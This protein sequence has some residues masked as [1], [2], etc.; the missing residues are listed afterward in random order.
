MTDFPCDLRHLG[1][2]HVSRE[3]RREVA[4]KAKSYEG[5][6]R[7]LVSRLRPGERFDPLRG[8]PG[9]RRLFARLR[10]RERRPVAPRRR[11]VGVLASP[12]LLRLLAPLGLARRLRAA[13]L[14]PRRATVRPEEVLAIRAPFSSAPGHRPVAGSEPGRSTFLRC[15]CGRRG[16]RAPLLATTTRAHPRPQRPRPTLPS[17]VVRVSRERGRTLRPTTGSTTVRRGPRALRRAVVFDPVRRSATR[18]RGIHVG[19]DSPP[20]DPEVGPFAAVAPRAAGGIRWALHRRRRAWA[21]RR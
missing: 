10:R 15:R 19:V 9:Q 21:D 11:V 7:Y 6:R 1:P 18:R 5:L 2:D 3:G 4:E 20:T 17:P 12:A 13:P 8:R 16:R 14:P